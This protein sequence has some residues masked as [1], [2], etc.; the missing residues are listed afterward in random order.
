MFC[1]LLACKNLKTWELFKF[2]N[3]KLKL[4]CTPTAMLASLTDIKRQF[5]FIL[6]CNWALDSMSECIYNTPHQERCVARSMGGNISK[7]LPC[8]HEGCTARVHKTCQIDWLQQH[9]VE[10]GYND[11]SFCQQHNECYQN[12]VRSHP[13]FPLR[14]L[15]TTS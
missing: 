13:A 3:I 15:W 10:W 9:G 12:Y 2:L 5:C 6:F 11:L 4:Q 7:M 1:K 8:A 14:R